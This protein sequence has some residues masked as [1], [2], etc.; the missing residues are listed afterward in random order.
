M[1]WDDYPGLTGGPKI[2]NH[3]NPYKWKKKAELGRGLKEENALLLALKIKG[4][5]TKEC[6]CPLEAGRGKETILP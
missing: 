2:I 5:Q 4:P 3:K 1:R 6:R